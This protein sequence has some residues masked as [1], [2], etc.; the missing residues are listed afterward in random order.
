MSLMNFCADGERAL[1]AVDTKTWHGVAQTHR[2][3]A[4]AFVLAHLDCVL[5]GNGL[6]SFAGSVYYD[7]CE[8][9]LG[10]F[11]EIED[12]MPERL[13]RIYSAILVEADK[14]S[15]GDYARQSSQAIALIGWSPRT[16]AMRAVQ[17][18]LSAADPSAGFHTTESSGAWLLN[19]P[20][21]TPAGTQPLEFVK[22]AARRQVEE[23]CPHLPF[24]AIG[25]DLVVYVLERG[26][27]TCLVVP[28]SEWI[29]A[30]GAGVR[31]GPKA[32]NQGVEER[33]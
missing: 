7:I 9:G 24:G 1:V 28:E 32:A 26:R 11:D 12:S 29:D 25:G 5:A 14:A 10:N 18:S 15:M 13:A 22:E 23:H 19:P 16:S 2:A 6:G 3:G 8:A 20:V 4:K 31:N 17:W 21:S 33:L 27:T 30:K